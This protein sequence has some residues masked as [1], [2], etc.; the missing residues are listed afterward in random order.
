MRTEKER[1]RQ[2]AVQL[3][4]P[5]TKRLEYVRHEGEINKTNFYITNKK[6]SM[7]DRPNGK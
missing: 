5:F 3:T 6:G 2:K 4:A 1:E 7:M